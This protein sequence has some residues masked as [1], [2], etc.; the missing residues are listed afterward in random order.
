[1]T[2]SGLEAVGKIAQK[3]TSASPL[4]DTLPF[5]AAEAAHLLGAPYAL[6]ILW[7][8][9][10][11]V[12]QVGATFGFGADLLQT[13]NAA[14]PVADGI[15]MRALQ[16][17]EL[18]ECQFDSKSNPAILL[19][20]PWLAALGIRAAAAV[21][22]VFAEQ[23]LGALVAY[24]DSSRPLSGDERIYLSMLGHMS[25][26]AIYQAQI[27]DFVLTNV[28]QTDAIF[29]NVPAG[30]AYF[31][32]QLN[33]IRTNFLA[34]QFL[35]EMSGLR[36]DEAHS[37]LDFAKHSTEIRIAA[38]VA[39]QTGVSRFLDGLPLGFGYVDLALVPMGADAGSGLLVFFTDATARVRRTELLEEAIADRTRELR[40][41][42]ERLVAANALKADFVAI[43]SHEL[44]TPMTAIKGYAM[45]LREPDL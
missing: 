25:S 10:S 16:D 12:L 32:S 44:R 33:L 35:A 41:A 39:L 38:H 13:V 29:S 15:A 28:R 42:N 5:I 37:F 30:V 17:N 21:P 27:L 45:L 19:L 31:N 34:D 8:E 7:N 9:A 3:L 20:E 11:G 14:E 36:P 24:W 40:E 23:R 2:S 6:L 43:A 1:M 22:L 4:A 26:A 18:V